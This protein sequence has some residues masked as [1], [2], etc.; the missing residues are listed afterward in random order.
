MADEITGVWGIIKDLGGATK[1]ALATN[2]TRQMSS[3]SAIPSV[4]GKKDW[5]LPGMSWPSDG[6]RRVDFRIYY[7]FPV[8]RN[9]D[10]TLTVEWKSGGK[11]RGKGLFVQN[12]LMTAHVASLTEG[13]D[14]KISGMFLD[15][16]GWNGDA[17]DPQPA[18]LEGYITVEVN[19]AIGGPV[20]FD[21]TVFCRGDGAGQCLPKYPLPPN[22]WN[23][24]P[25]KGT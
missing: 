7:W 9:T 25:N 5:P 20:S 12:A 1:A 24:N 13:N 14:Y 4:D 18:Y 17:S 6:D 19:Q 23:W 15:P 8:S 22:I 16:P 2:V 21:F 11:Y 3:G 10:I